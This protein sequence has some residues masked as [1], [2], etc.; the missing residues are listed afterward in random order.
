MAKKKFYLVLDVE[1]ANSTDDP[2]VYDL[3]GAVCDKKGNIY[4]TFSFIVRDIFD[5]E[6]DL[7]QSAY[8]AKKIPLYH[9]G[10]NQGQFQ[11]VS[12][13]TARKHV[14]D[15]IKCYSITEVYAYNANFDRNAL[16][17]TQRWLSKSKYRYF[18][19]FGV[20][21]NCIWHMACQTI[22]S[23]KTYYN[24]ATAN[25]LVSPAGNLKTS[26]ETVYAYIS[27]QDQFEEDHTGLQDVLI[28]VA[29]LA[30]VFRQHKKVDRSI[31]RL[32]WR[33]PQKQG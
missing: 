32:C 12:F 30:H 27:N 21:F 18:L 23:Q 22:C 26:A 28:E 5:L 6:S 33:I 15:L 20:K 25:G 3:G 16:N 29:I 13:Y 9:N 1:T 7:M 31:N 11:R 17:K 10:L 8:Y 2:L 19:P 4:D 14:L 24:W